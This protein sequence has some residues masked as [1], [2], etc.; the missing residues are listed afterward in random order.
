MLITDVETQ[1]QKVN[2]QNES[3]SVIILLNK[4]AEFKGV[5]K[6]F[7]LEMSGKK[8]WKYVE[9]A[10]AG[11]PIKTTMCTME[12][13]IIKLVKPMLTQSMF[14]LVLYSDTPLIQAS[15]I[16][17]IIDYAMS[18]QVNVMTLKRGFLF[19]TEYLKSVESV[20]GGL[21]YFVHEND[22]LQVKDAAW[23][24]KISSILKNRI[25]DFHLS[26]GII[27]KDKATTF[28]D[29]DVILESGVIIEPHNVIKGQSFIGKN[30][31]LNPFNVIENS[32]IKDN[33]V[34]NGAYIKNSK[35]EGGQTIDIF[36]KIVG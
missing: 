25:L 9:L 7:D 21:E 13:D 26:N 18:Y 16:K 20:Q 23:F 5:M 35:I 31:Q 32:I 22:F 19:N 28:I 12:T 3:V 17:E 15:T 30:T 10:C 33:C 36:E 34:L 14:T 27:I 24:E 4:N 29:A 8:M 11:Y 1:T 2:V 6:P